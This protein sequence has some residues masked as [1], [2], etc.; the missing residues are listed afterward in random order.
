MEQ[1]DMEEISKQ[2]MDIMDIWKHFFQ[3]DVEFFEGDKKEAKTYMEGKIV[4]SMP[5]RA[6]SGSQ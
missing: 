4:Y 3:S 6:I 2:H 5:C 1:I